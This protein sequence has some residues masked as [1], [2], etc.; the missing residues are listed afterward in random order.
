MNI[1]IRTLL[2]TL[3]VQYSFIM[4]LLIGS[5]MFLGFVFSAKAQ[6]I[7]ACDGESGAAF[8]L[9][10]AYCEAMDCDGFPNAAAEACDTVRENYSKITGNEQLPCERVALCDSAGSCT[11]FATRSTTGGN[12]GGLS[13]A[14]A[15]CQSRA[16]EASL[17]GKY[18]AWLSTSD[19]T[20]PATRFATATVPY[21]RVDGAIIADN[22]SD[23]T[24][25]TLYNPIYLD[26]DGYPVG[27]TAWT[28][29]NVDGT[30]KGS[31]C[32]DWQSTDGG[33]QSG[34]P[35]ATDYKWTAYENLPNV[36]CRNLT[37][38]FYCF[39]Q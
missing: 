32:N 31:N 20:S 38:A 12:L 14:D 15:I 26:A 17:S 34:Y 3:V 11:V 9:C 25:G 7:N 16:V 35:S 18:L 13:G 29:T 24:D 2:G 37:Q 8:G 33:A 22:W 1:S 10:F 23:L 6:T 5:I 21:V 30:P 39:E 36:P 4:I 28:G 27:A 19:G